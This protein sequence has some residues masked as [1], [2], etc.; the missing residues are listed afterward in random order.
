MLYHPT[1]VSSFGWIPQDTS[2]R[3]SVFDVMTQYYGEE[4][5]IQLPV[6]EEQISF[7]FQP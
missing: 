7:S 1:P 5:L 6:N 2:Q 4:N 3:D